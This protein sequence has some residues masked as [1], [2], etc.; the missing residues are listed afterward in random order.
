MSMRLQAKRTD[1]RT[2]TDRSQKTTDWQKK[3]IS[4]EGRSVKKTGIIRKKKPVSGKHAHGSCLRNVPISGSASG[5]AEFS[6]FFECFEHFVCVFHDFVFDCIKYFVSGFDEFV[7]FHRASG[8]FSF[9][10]SHADPVIGKKIFDSGTDFRLFQTCFSFNDG[11]SYL[12]V[13]R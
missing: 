11:R 13:F 12:F 7:I 1:R 10:F 6:E 2:E 5:S 4:S 8:F 3:K 9:D